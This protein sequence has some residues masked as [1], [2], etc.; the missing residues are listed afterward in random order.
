MEH[1]KHCQTWCPGC[2]DEPGL[3][4]YEEERCDR[5]QSHVT[6]T[7]EMA[8]ALKEQG[9]GVTAPGELVWSRDGSSHNGTLDGQVRGWLHKGPE[10]IR[11]GPDDGWHTLIRKRADDETYTWLGILAGEAEA[12]AA[13]QG[14]LD[15]QKA[16]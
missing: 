14:V 10:L 12:K 6:C 1:Q 3:L 8:E 9:F 15:Q 13:V 5:C 4:T 7:C 2:Q 16:G 11:L